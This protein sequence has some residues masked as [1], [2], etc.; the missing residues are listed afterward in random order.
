[1]KTEP[2][3]SDNGISLH[4]GIDISFY[5]KKSESERY[6]LRQPGMTHH[7]EVFHLFDLWR[8]INHISH[9]WSRCGYQAIRG[10]IVGVAL[11]PR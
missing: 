7:R 5:L 11:F 8:L 9:S 4:D 1:M 3:H 6:Y 10:I 2:Q